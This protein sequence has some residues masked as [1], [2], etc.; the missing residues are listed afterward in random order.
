MAEEVQG[1]ISGGNGRERLELRIGT[2]SFG[3]QAKDLIPILLLCLIGIG[4]FLIYRGVHDDLGRLSAQQGDMQA[5][6]HR[7]LLEASQ[8][9]H[10]TVEELK[11]L[12]HAQR[13]HLDQ[14]R[15]MVRRELAE[16]AE[17][18]RKLMVYHDMNQG[19]EPGNRIPL[20]FPQ[21]M[22]PDT[23]KK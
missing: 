7:D 12:V 15:D 21:P 11:S 20:E 1:S 5:T 4:G 22:A 18:L 14:Q 13:N 6:Q 8:L 9:W 16:Q 19:R 2:K 23:D 17:A 3:V 10:E